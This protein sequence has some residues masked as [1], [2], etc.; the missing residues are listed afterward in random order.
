MKKY[1]TAAILVGSCL[2]QNIYAQQSFVNYTVMNQYA[3]DMVYDSSI[4]K[5]LISI[6]SKDNVH[7]KDRKSVV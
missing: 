2:S 3:N 7:G 4:S 6:P 5:I 1:L